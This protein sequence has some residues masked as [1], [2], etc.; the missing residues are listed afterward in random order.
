MPSRQAGSTVRQRKVT[1]TTAAASRARAPAS[2]GGM[3]KFY[4]DDSPGI[5]V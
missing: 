3:W 1:S 4:T 5:K 2:S